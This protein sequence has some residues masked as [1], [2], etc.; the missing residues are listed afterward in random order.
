[1]G[2][3]RY[4]GVSHMM[5]KKMEAALNKQINAELYS[6]YLYLS[7]NSYFHSINLQ[8]FAGWMRVQALEEMTHADKF[9]KFMVDRGGRVI[10]DVIDKPPVKWTSPLAVFEDVL[11]HELKVTSLI[12]S[13]V[14]LAITEKDH[15]TNATLQWFV[16]EQ[17][18]EEANADAIVH[19]LKLIGDNGYG[20]LMLD[21][22]LAQRVF[23]PP[24]QAQP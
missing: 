24:V 6:A 1:M 9:Y 20:I 5:S 11:K 4:K 14:D 7:M 18:E 15:A 19:K 10:L 13:L 22:E 23:I 21:S 8:G 3:G 17:V 12:H 16:N 2:F